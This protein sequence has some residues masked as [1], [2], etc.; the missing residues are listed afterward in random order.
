MQETNFEIFLRGTLFPRAPQYFSDE[1]YEK[2]WLDMVSQLQPRDMIFTARL[3]GRVSRLIAWSTGGPFSHVGVY[4]GDGEMWEI[5]TSGERVVPI[6]T[7]K[8]R[9]FR[10]AV[11]RTFFP[12]PKPWAE[13]LKEM[14]GRGIGYDYLGAI[15]HGVRSFF[16]EHDDSQAPNSLIYQGRLALIAQA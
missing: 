14:Q 3:D 1:G 4:L 7:Y 2:A 8:G 6:S 11:Y 10:T 13:A 9:E 12:P 16:G 15:Q 5:V